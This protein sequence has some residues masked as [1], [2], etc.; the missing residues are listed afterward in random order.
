MAIRATYTLRA[1]AATLLLAGAATIASASPA[2][3]AK[4]ANP[5]KKVPVPEVK[6]VPGGQDVVVYAKEDVYAC[7]PS[8]VRT[9]EGGAEVLYARFATRRKVAG[10]HPHTDATG[11]SATYASRDGGR[12]W[13]P[14]DRFPGDDAVNARKDGGT[15]Y[16][17]VTGWVSIPAE[18]RAEYE[19]EGHLVNPSRPGVAAYLGGAFSVL[20]KPGESAGD[21]SAPGRRR[22]LPGAETSVMMGY[23]KPLKTRAGV[24]L[25]PIYG[26]AA[27]PVPRDAN[28]GGWETSYVARS[29]DDGDTWSLV[30][31]A[32]PTTGPTGG[33]RLGFNETALAEL[34]DGRIVAMMRPSPDTVG[35]LYRS[36]SADGGK[37]WS[38]PSRTP[39]WGYPADL[40][41][42]KDGS[43]LCTYGYRRAPMGV[44]A[45]VSRDGGASWDPGREIVLR[46]DGA[47]GGGDNGYP[48]TVQM[49]DGTLVT[50]YYLTTTASKLPFVAATRWRVPEGAAAPAPAPA[51]P[52]PTAISRGKAAGTYQAFPDACRLKSGEIVAVFYAG[53]GHV[54]MPREPDWPRGGRVCLVRSKDDGKTW[55]EPTV[56]YDSPDDDRD[57][58]VARMP[59]GSLLVTLFSLHPTGKET[60][61]WL[62]AGVKLVRSADEGKTWATEARILSPAGADWYVSAPV[63]VLP[64]GTWMLGVYRYAGPGN[65]YG[66]VLRSTDAGKTWSEPIPI[67]KGQEVPLDAETDVIAL[68]DGT[69]FAALRCGQKDRNLHY[70]LSGDDG[71][72]WTEARDIGFP[73]HAPFLHRTRDG[74]IVMAHRLP[75]TSLHV[76]RDEGKTWQGPYVVDE[77]FGAYASIVEREDG[78]LLVVYYTEGKDSHVRVRRFRLT[79]GGLEALPL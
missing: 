7:F 41:V 60:P 18:K 47:G 63:R 19:A 37:T 32:A 42:L 30:T 23:G 17:G 5:E 35:H 45:A 10:S 53:Y 40:L 54:S 52:T 76:S 68:K 51:G 28:K 39:L 24:R 74:A 20:G 34:P 13:Q 44:R 78:S 56:V 73:G 58:H 79:P 26:A 70:A 12:T 69:L 14:A 16:V 8:L 38:A 55:S 21:A 49:D 29:E 66:G 59:D 15:A 61:K 62:G 33:Q 25:T 3:D 46:A 9:V 71:K 43:L 22:P 64:S 67:G 2:D 6:T 65:V 31:I 72:T 77:V 50:A 36:V 11:G 4:R 57:P 1:L 48:Q 27:R 75:N